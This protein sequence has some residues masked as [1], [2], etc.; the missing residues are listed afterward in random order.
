MKPSTMT[1][2]E[3]VDFL[4][5]VLR[6]RYS[7]GAFPWK[8]GNI[9]L[10][11]FEK[12]LEDF[13]FIGE[14]GLLLEDGRTDYPIPPVMR[15]LRGIYQ[16][17]QDADV[18]IPYKP[19][20][21]RF[22]QVNGGIRLDVTPTISEEE[23]IEGTVAAGAPSD[24]DLVF[25]D[26]AGKLDDTLE[27]DELAGRVIRVVH[28]DDTEE[29]R[30]LRGNTPDDTTA[31]LN[32]DLL[33]VAAPGDEYLITANFYMLEGLLYLPRLAAI[34]DVLPIPAD[35]EACFMAHLRY[36][37]E[38]QSEEGSSN[39]AFWYREYRRELATIKSDNRHRV[40]NPVK[41]PRPL[42]PFFT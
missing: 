30:I 5:R 20:P 15:Q 25:D 14:V 9:I 36:R 1:L 32:G 13:Y 27:D 16:V 8:A 11:D 2:E 12:E 31:N 3:A 24:L 4:P 23:D 6:Q 22:T 34:D 26:T 42:P 29:W 28:A 33:A 18:K 17:L 41:R 10:A 35:W 19:D 7:G 38:A 37:Y 21:I 39:T 40:D